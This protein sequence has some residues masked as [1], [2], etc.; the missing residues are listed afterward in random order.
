MRKLL[1]FIAGSLISGS[2]LAGGLVTNNNH[3]AM[4]TRLLNRNASTDIDAVY[5]NPAGLTKLSD[6]FYFSLNNQTI[7]QTQ[8][9]TNNYVY[10][11][12]TN[13]GTKPREFIGKV[14]APIYPAVYVAYKKGKLALSAG[15]NPIGGGGG[16]EYKDGLPSFEMRVADLV[17]GLQAQLAPLDQGILTATGTDP[18]FRNVTGYSSDIYFKGSSIYF[19]YQAN[20][21]YAINDMLSVAVGGRF[22][23][24]KNT[25]EGYIQGVTIA[26]PEG[27]GGSQTPGDYL[28]F[29]AA[30]PGVPAGTA[31]LLNGTALYLD[32]AT[33]VEADAVMK[34]TGFTP[35]LSANISPSEK[36]NIALRYE[37][38]TKLNLKTTV[39]D[40]KDA[41]GMFIQDSVAIADI[42]AAISLGINFKPVERLLLSGSF[43]YY[44]D[45][46]VDYD[47]QPDVSVNMIDKN[48]LE[49]GIGAE[50]AVTEK[51]RISAGWAATATGVNDEYQSDL[52]FSTNTN[53]VGAGFGY[54][55][56][57]MIDLNVG[58]EYAFY[59]EGTKDFN[60]YLDATHSIPVTETYNKK[61]WLVGVGLNFHFGK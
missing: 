40:G 3:S 22:I 26:A 46:G 55:I 49:F 23:S 58:A 32:D 36:L 5:F 44:F 10:L 14:S 48:F 2:L 34:G 35:I 8:T 7:G 57:D 47:G 51:L 19:G 50:Y 56:N 16:A 6:G 37:F 13:G 59:A 38:K 27:Y 11:N 43:S 20:V 9:V 31:A 60:H 45:N 33:T 21:S 18:Y 15:F 42:P 54:R 39:N 29:V 25:Y 17:P 1:T 41:E 12:G 52:N 30:V 61:T 24:A 4:F 28:R 53:S